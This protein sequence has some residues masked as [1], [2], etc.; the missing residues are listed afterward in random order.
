[1]FLNSFD[2]DVV[3]EEGFIPLDVA[4]LCEGIDRQLEPFKGFAFGLGFGAL[5]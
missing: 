3:A 4:C 2:E 1:M 5:V